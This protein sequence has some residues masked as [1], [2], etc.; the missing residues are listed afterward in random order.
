MKRLL[1]TACSALLAFAASSSA[2]GTEPVTTVDEFDRTFTFDCPQGFTL[3][4]HYTGTETIRR[5]GDRQQT[6]IRLVS[7]FTNSVTGSTFRSTTAWMYT[8]Y[9]ENTVSVVGVTFRLT[10]PGQGVI[11]LEAGRVVYDWQTGKVV[12]DAGPSQPLTNFCQP[13]AG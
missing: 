4:E 8:F 10:I 3:I 7:E 12:F 6:Q 9:P 2:E 5:F 11:A 13:F 1:V